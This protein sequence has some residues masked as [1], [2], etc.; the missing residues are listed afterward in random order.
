VVAAEPA[1]A[2]SAATD[3]RDSSSLAMT[4]DDAGVSVPVLARY[5]VGDDQV[6]RRL[7]AR[8]VADNTGHCEGCRSATGGTPV[9]PCTLYALAVEVRALNVRRR[10]SDQDGLRFTP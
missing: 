10:A 1:A 8:H 6:W 5:L 9:W 4:P 7:L 3:G 2:G